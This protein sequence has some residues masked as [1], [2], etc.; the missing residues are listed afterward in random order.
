[1]ANKHIRR[2]MTMAVKVFSISEYTT[3]DTIDA[4]VFADTKEEVSDDMEIEGI[5]KGKV[6]SYGS[7][8][9]TANGDIA[10]LKSDGTWN[11]VGE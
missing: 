2:D 3:D 9:I 6:I 5:P 8:L 4:L 10:F 1:M 11:F 7:S